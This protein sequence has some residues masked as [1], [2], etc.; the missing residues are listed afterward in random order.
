MEP[1]LLIGG[2]GHCRVIIDALQASARFEIVG[3]LDVSASGGD[4]MGV[5]VIG[6]DEDLARV[7]AEGVAS[8]FIAVGSMGDP[9]R[10]VALANRV[11]AEG[12]RLPQVVH[13]TAYVSPNAVLGPG[14]YVGPQ[15]AV[16]AGASIGAN[17]IV[18]TG[19]LVDHDCRIGEFVHLAPGCALSGGVSVGDRTHLGTGCAVVHGVSIGRDTIVGA[20]SVVVADVEPGVVAFGNPC[21]VR[22]ANAR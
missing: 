21:R 12:F 17:A 10:R 22:R 3:I 5:P 11:I 16:N 13:P 18:N 19:A 9:T 14:V 7:R 6:T 20:G 1:L 8:A 2:G 4:V 15:A